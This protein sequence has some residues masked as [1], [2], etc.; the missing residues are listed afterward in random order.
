VSITVTGR[1]WVYITMCW[2]L[3]VDGVGQFGGYTWTVDDD[4]LVDRCQ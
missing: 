4:I 1:Y 2:L 3:I